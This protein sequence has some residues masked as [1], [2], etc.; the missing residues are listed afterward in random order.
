M[1]MKFPF[2]FFVYEDNLSAMTSL[3]AMPWPNKLSDKTSLKFIT[4][5]NIVNMFSAK[6][7]NFDFLREISG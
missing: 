3:I 5:I 1:L 4:D 2:V 6:F 7:I